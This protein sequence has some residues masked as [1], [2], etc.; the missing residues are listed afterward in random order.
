MLEQPVRIRQPNKQ[1]IGQVYELREL[2]KHLAQRVK[3][4]DGFTD[5]SNR[6]PLDIT[7][8]YREPKAA[9]AKHDSPKD[10][11]DEEI[12][13]DTPFSIDN[14]TVGLEANVTPDFVLSD[15]DSN[16]DS[17]SEYSA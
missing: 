9:A 14:P 7:D 11:H 8:I 12:A 15:S 10:K 4:Q 2:R 5:P 6:N 1:F 16:S 3:H 17:D 13:S